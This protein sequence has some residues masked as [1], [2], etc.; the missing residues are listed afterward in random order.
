MPPNNT[1]EL[2]VDEKDVYLDENFF[3]KAG[4]VTAKNTEDEAKNQNESKRQSII[5]SNVI[6]ISIFHLLAVYMLFAY[7]FRVKT[8][9]FLWGM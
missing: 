3:E 7:T 9:T 5:W 6:L 2:P 4:L 1:N 8:Q